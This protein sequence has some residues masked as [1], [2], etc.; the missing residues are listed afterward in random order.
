MSA[1]T[2]R[3]LRCGCGQHFLF[4]EFHWP[5]C[6]T[7]PANTGKNNPPAVKKPHSEFRAKGR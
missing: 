1:H 5:H 3:A 7:N 2:S 4:P 6:R